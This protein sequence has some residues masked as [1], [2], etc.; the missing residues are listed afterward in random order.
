MVTGPDD[1]ITSPVRYMTFVDG[2]ALTSSFYFSDVRSKTVDLDL[3]MEG[4]ASWTLES[5][6]VFHHP[7]A[8]YFAV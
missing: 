6:E 5:L 3:D 1:A 4:D 8:R 7:D 2:D